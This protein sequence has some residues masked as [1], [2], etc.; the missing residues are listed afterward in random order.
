[1]AEN[2][3]P[4]YNQASV[5]LNTESVITEI[6]PGMLTYAL[7][8]SVQNFDGITVTYQNDTANVGCITFPS[9]YRVVGA[10]NIPQ[11]K[12][13]LYWLANPSTGYS[14]LLYSDNDNCTYN[15]Y[16]DDTIP[17]SDKLNF[18]INYPILKVEIKTTNCD[19]E[20][21]WT[22]R[23]N[24]RR[25][26][27][28]DKLPWKDTFIGGVATPVPGN[29][30]NNKLLVQPSFDVPVI[31]ATAVNI[32]GTLTEGTYQFVMA[33][34][35]VLGNIYTSYYSNSNPVRIFLDGKTSENFNEITNKSIALTITNLDTSG[36]YD[37][38][39]LVVV[40]T[41]NGIAS[42]E[43]VS[44]MPINGQDTF[45]YGYTGD[46]AD[47][48]NIKVNLQDIFEQTDYYDIAGDLTQVDNVLV[49]ADLIRED[50]ISYQ[51]IWNQVKMGWGSWRVPYT[52]AEGYHNG[53][54][55]AN[56]LGFFRDEVVPVEGRF[57][58]RNGKRTTRGLLIGRTATAFDL[59][60]IPGSNP[61]TH[62]ATS[63]DNCAPPL[64]NP[65]RWKVYNTGS[66]TGTDSGFVPGDN[67]YKGPYQYGEFGYWESDRRYP[68]NPAIW[69]ALAN[70]PI[71]H[72]KFPDNI[73]SSI[74]DENPYPVGSDA[75]NNFEHA[76]YPI[77]IKIDIN[78]LRSA[79]QSSSD[80]T[81][82]QKDDIVGFEVMRGDRVNEKSIIA[83]G[84]LFNVGKYT[85][86]N[87]TYYYP[88]YPFND[89]S[90]DP[91]ISSSPV[92]DK[93]GPN[94]GTRLN[95]FQST[96]FTFHS[97][98]T[99][100]F[101]PSA[102]S[103]AMLKLETVESGNCKAHFIPVKD[104][105]K[106]KL[107][108][109]KALQIA[110]AAGI[111]SLVGLNV[112]IA[113]QVGTVSSITTTI[114]PTIAAQNFFPTFNS[115][116]D[117]IDKL[118]PYYNYGWQYNGIGYYGNSNGVSNGGNKIR[119]I[120]FGGYIN[121][122]LEKTFGDDHS[123]N[124]SFRESSVYLSVSDNLPYAGLDTSR[125]TAG[126]VGLCG[127]S[128]VFYRNV[129]SYYGSIKKYL[130]AQWGEVFSYNVVSTG[131][132]SNFKDS[133]GNDIQDMPIVF[134]GDC[135]INRFALKRKHSFFNK[136]SVNKV[137]GADIDYNQ[138]TLSHTNTGNVGYP[139]WYYS[140]SNKLLN[141]QN[142]PI[143]GQIANFI[144]SFS[145]V[146]GIILSL[147][148]LGLSD[149]LQALLLI[150]MMIS[151]GIL[152]TL[153][154]KITNLECYSGDDL[155]EKGQAYQYAY[156][157]P[158]YFCESEVN[159]DMRQATNLKEGN[160][161]PN[162]GGDIPDD[163]CSETFVPI[164][165][166]N[167]YVYN[168]TYSKQNK[169]SFYQILRPDWTPGNPCFVNFPNLAIWSD[170]SNLEETKNNWLV[171][172]PANKF[173]FPKVYGKLTAIDRIKD[174][175]V[176]VRYENAAELYNATVTIATSTLQ[177][178]IGTGDLFSGSQPI[179]LS[180]S[181]VG[182]SGSQHKMLLKTDYGAIWADAKRGQVC[183]VSPNSMNVESLEQR[184]MA[185]WFYNN[186]PFTIQ[187]YFPN[188]NIDNNYNGIGLHGVYDPYY[189]RIFITKKDYKPL[190]YRIKYNGE[191]FYIDGTAIPGTTDT[192]TTTI[193][194][195]SNCCPD[196]YVVNNQN[197]EG[198]C[199]LAEDSSSSS[200]ST[201]SNSS[202][203]RPSMPSNLPRWTSFVDCPPTVITTNNSTDGY[204]PESVVSLDDPKLFCNKSWTISYSFLTNTWISWHSFLPNYYIPNV[205]YFQSGV[206]G[207]ESTLWNHNTIFTKW[208][209]YY[210]QIYPYILEYPFV[211]KYNDEILQN[212]KD[213]CTVIKYQDKTT[214]TEPKELI[215][216]DRCIIYNGQQTTG[217]LNLIPKSNNNLFEYIKYP[218]INSNSKDILV[219]KRDHFY[220]FNQ[221][222]DV[223][224][225]PSDNIWQDTCNTKFTDKLL[226]T[227]N[228][229]YSNKSFKKVPIRGKDTRV[230]LIKDTDN[231]CKLISKFIVAP[232]QNS[233]I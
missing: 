16:L 156:G 157:I 176:L 106:Q 162:V 107:R 89:V 191:S 54:N 186:L 139:I 141:I 27:A 185:K 24:K 105:S 155:F 168:D 56:L 33:Y 45:T 179:L 12:K 142:T 112:N 140:T 167:S 87:S 204:T 151:N 138:D 96:R 113:T 104:N 50:D 32:G 137:D 224:I 173:P 165:F 217:L 29:I 69:G 2:I 95:D 144:N 184:F 44:T 9:G 214:W 110:L 181:E 206:N 158:Y 177:A 180:N 40:K 136:S 4:N 218:I 120:K 70:Q 128:S 153:G 161:F 64:S 212:V 118:I 60:P 208:N 190:D 148:T 72:P 26:M 233:Y 160:F 159:V 39:N 8:A 115:M 65:P 175:A 81:Q 43:L 213:Y 74:H 192:T 13:V 183:L 55:C 36:L 59:D 201:S 67:C 23:F 3:N 53:A 221:F 111:V 215:Y 52:Q 127:S 146:P 51:K 126:Q 76:I 101:K 205:H 7:N 6:K 163:W 17:G 68:N 195:A 42:A 130:P 108:T 216:F 193:P 202:P 164:A 171:Y 182:A 85:K 132:Y 169:E 231:T 119:G 131:S 99:H 170:K 207:G 223:V 225:T 98:D 100:F 125:V 154:L 48:S 134:G 47:K 188:I 124:N 86:D 37:Y 21:Y 97:P 35:D 129:S 109:D 152:T 57:I 92:A 133:L 88:N 228:L 10:K 174:R 123:I 116:L 11:L 117:I 200:S 143:N 222:W 15:T 83:K 79:I 41:V 75:Y 46:E 78:S 135:F 150:V 38:F 219:D 62:A 145:T 147:L 82:E 25:Y 199:V 209:E 20:V 198:D 196:G 121:T 71:R 18:N 211:Y 178:S 172:R 1:M 19:T 73:I 66:V 203:I 197:Q 166:D 149:L 229:D 232:S 94:A 22:D 189:S 194:G 187:K 58:L 30:D 93:S 103:G 114:S 91:F 90:A 61:D 5:G 14:L 226:N 77:G 28:L 80:L 220:N 49:W 210:G 230:R 122:G 31:K 84:L 63:P 227:I 102:I 34:S